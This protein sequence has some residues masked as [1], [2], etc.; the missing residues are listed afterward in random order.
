M[1]PGI[2]DYRMDDAEAVVELWD[3]CLVRD[4]IT[5]GIFE[6]KVLLDPN[7][8]VGGCKV[9]E[10]DGRIVGFAHAVVRTTP[11]PRGFEALLEADRDKGWIV[12]LFVHPDQRRRGIGSALLDE[13]LQFIRAR[14]RK[15]A[16]LFNYT[17]NYLLVGVDREGYPGA[18]EFYRRHGF[19]PGGETVGMGIDLNGFVVPE[20]VWQTEAKLKEGGIEARPF[21]RRY[22]V[23]AVSFFLEHFPTW[24]HYFEDKLARGHEPDEMVIVLR[25]DEVVGYCQHRY[26]HHVERTGPFGVRADLRGKKVGTV[27]LHKLLERMAQKGYKYAWFTSTDLGTADYYAKAGYK[28]IRRHVG[29]ARGL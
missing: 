11:Y 21:D 7:F 13:A 2:R 14:G 22:I 29:M 12:A 5:R 19:E 23:P 4:P 9:A 17:P 3:R 27:M 15:Q 18:L 24:L 28:V 25:G 8:D 10:A 16:I 6:D 1:K 26:Y 20:A